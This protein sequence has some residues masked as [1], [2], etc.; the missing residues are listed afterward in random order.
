MPYDLTFAGSYFDVTDFLKDV[1][2]L[3]RSGDASQVS[4]DGRL[5][6]VNAFS[7]DLPDTSA[8]SASS[9]NPQLQVSLSVTSYLTPGDQGATAGASPTGPG[10]SLTQPTSATVTP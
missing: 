1:D 8:G 9:P 10:T 6:T 5:L 4:A 7:L 2:D 3:V